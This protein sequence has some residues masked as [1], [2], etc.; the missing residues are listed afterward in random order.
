MKQVLAVVFAG[1]LAMPAFAQEKAEPAKAPTA[2]RVQVVLSRHQGDRKLS[3]RPYTLNVSTGKEFQLQQGSQVPIPVT[4]YKD[5]R[6]AVSFQYKNVGV[7]MEMKAEAL[8]GGRYMLGFAIE[9]SSFADGPD[10]HDRQVAPNLRVPM[11]NTHE[12]RSAIVIRDGETVTFTNTQS[13]TGS[14]DKV[15]IT[16]NVLK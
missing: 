11:F 6:E 10:G 13:L 4:Q 16:V 1:V 12:V 14:V 7:N 2:L 9:D 15:E 8:E 5:G 3:S